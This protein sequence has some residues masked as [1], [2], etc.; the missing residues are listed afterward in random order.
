MRPQNYFTKILEDNIKATIKPQ[1]VDHIPKAVRGLVGKILQDKDERSAAEDFDC[2][3]W[4]HKKL[5]LS[6][7]LD[8]DVAVLSGGELQ[9][10]AIAAVVVQS[11][12]M[13]VQR[14]EWKRDKRQKREPRAT[15]SLTRRS[16]RAKSGPKLASGGSKRAASDAFWCYPFTN[17]AFWQTS[18]AIACS[19]ARK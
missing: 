19:A 9:R 5:E 8:R 3:A 1:Y 13:Y 10:F 14:S 16:K 2:Y 18:L 17:R 12:D 6:H 11:S 15:H 4:I 7:V